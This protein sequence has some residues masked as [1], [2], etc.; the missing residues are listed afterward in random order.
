MLRALTL[1]MFFAT[2]TAN[3]VELRGSPDEARALAESAAEFLLQADDRHA[4]LREMTS[5][6]QRFVDRDL[7]VFVLDLD[8]N[9]LA[10]GANP[11]I[12]GKNLA[13]MKDA[14]GQLISVNAVNTALDKQAGWTPRYRFPD[15][16]TKR[17]GVKQSYVI[18]VEELVV[19]V[20]FYVDS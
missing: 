11:R 13:K 4:A 10:H 12:V 3:A 17:L 20:G 14:D 6:Q 18:L 15:P 8:I 19:G 2:S 16:I 1:L 9:L 5:P 7:Y